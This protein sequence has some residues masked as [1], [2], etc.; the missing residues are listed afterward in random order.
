[1]QMHFYF[2]IFPKIL[3]ARVKKFSFES[4]THQLY[5]KKLWQGISVGQRNNQI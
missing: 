5:F 4:I 3:S 2:I 1:M